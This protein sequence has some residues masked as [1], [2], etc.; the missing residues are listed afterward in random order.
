MSLKG[1]G[2]S[3]MKWVR[4]EV[5]RDRV[6]FMIGQRTDWPRYRPLNGLGPGS[7]LKTTAEGEPGPF[8]A[9]SR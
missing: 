7:S 5:Q 8:L 4:G 3:N 2:I 9:I 1:G 6:P